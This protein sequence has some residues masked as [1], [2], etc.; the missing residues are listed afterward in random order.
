MINVTPMIDILLVLLITF[1]LLPNTSHGL[2]ATAPEPAPDRAS[3]APNPLDAVL[4]LARD[5]SIEI[6]SQ[7]VPRPE[8]DARLR[9]AFATRPDGVLF[10]DG[11]PSSNTPMS[12]A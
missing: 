8:L 9:L 4:R 2:P 11:S 10:V 5:R 3:A 1:M 12:Q 6:N 7:P